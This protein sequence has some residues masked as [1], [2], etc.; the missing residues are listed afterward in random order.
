MQLVVRGLRPVQ[1]ERPEQSLGD[2]GWRGTHNGD[3]VSGSRRTA[4]CVRES[5]VCD[6]FAGQSGEGRRQLG[7]H[8]LRGV[9]AKQT[10]NHPRVED[11]HR[12][13]AGEELGGDQGGQVQSRFPG[14][15]N[16]KGWMN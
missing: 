16:E 13:R 5:R 4:G 12:R 10:Q 7:G 6:Q 14:A 8:D 2:A 15:T 11:I 9:G 1:L 3:S